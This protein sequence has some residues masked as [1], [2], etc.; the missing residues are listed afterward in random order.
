MR[1]TMRYQ[2]GIAMLLL[3]CSLLVTWP[4]AA[5]TNTPS[6]QS[7]VTITGNEVPLVQVFRA[8]K[9][10]T[11]LTL[12]YSNQLL[13]DGEKISLNF[14]QAKLNDV[15]SFIFKNKN[16]NYVLQRNRI[17]LDKKELLPASPSATTQPQETTQ[18]AWLVRGI[19]MDPDGNPLPGATIAITGTSQGTVTD[20]MGVFSIKAN[21][22]DVLKIGMI[23][24]N[25][26][27]VKISS[28]KTLKVTLTAKVDKLNEVVVVGFG[29]QKKVTVTGA[30]SSVNMADM[31]S[32]VPSLTNALVGRVAGVISMQ[33]N[34]G[35]P[36]YDAPTFTIRGIGTFMGNKSPLIIVDGVQREDVNSTYGGAFNNIDPE[37]IQSISLLKDASA[38]AVYGAKGANG[39]LIITTKKGIAGKPK[40]S[41]KA[42][43]GL[44]GFAVLPKMLDGVNYMKLY[45]EARVND[46]NSPVYTEE[47]IRKTESGLDP[48]LYPNVDWVNT[49]YKKWA[50]MANTNVNVSGGGEAMRYYV[51]MSFYNQDGQYNVTK[52]NGYNPNL[53]FKR[54]DFRSNVDLNLTKTTLL[55]L[56]LSSM[57]VNTRY[58][59]FPAKGI[60]YSTYAANPIMLP[61]KYPDRNSGPTNNGGNNPFNMVQN[62]GY[63]TEFR[64]TIQSVLSL[65]QKLDA[66]TEG[67]SATARFSFDTYSEFDNSRK[68]PN[69]LYNASGRNPDGSL[70]YSL[71]RQGVNY[72]PYSS[73]SSGERM[74]YL[75][76]NLNYDR[77]FGKHNIGGL[78]V[79][80]IRNRLIGSA[81]NLKLSIPF[82]N[83][84]AAAR[85]TY[86][87]MD[88]YLAEVNMGA[89]G[90]ENFAPGKR[91]G[92]FPAASVG[93]V[94]SKEPFFDAVSKTIS[95]LKVRAS[96]GM[97]GND[98]IGN[99]D[100]FGY[101]TY[102]DG[103]SGQ[104]FG[105]TG[106]PVFTGGIATKVIGTENLTWEKSAKTN[107]GL[108][109][110]LFN[111]FNLV[112][113]AFRDQRSS[114][115][116]LRNSISPIGGYS[117]LTIYGNIGEMDNRGMDGSIEYTE[118]LG[119]D[120]SLRVF[121]NVTYAKNKIVNADR[122]KSLYSYYPTSGYMYGELEG[123]KSLGLFVNKDDVQNNPKQFRDV[124]YPGDIKYADL[125]GDGR[126]DGS[127]KTYL[128]KS[129]FPKWS[130]GFGF[131]LGYKR[132]ELS[133]VFAGVADVA[134]MA[135][136]QDISFEDYGTP[137]VGVVPFTG[138]GQYP[139][140]IISDVLN[141]WTPENPSQNVHYPRITI[142]NGSDN[143]YVNSDWWLRD[144]SF[145]RLRQATLSYSIITAAM[146][147]KGIS[148]LQVYTGATNMLTFSRFK[149]WDP[150]L[151]NNAAKYPFT[152]TVTLGLRAQF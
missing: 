1:K 22:E 59:G 73:S 61:V 128:G 4:S 70:I 27:E 34:G 6:L 151:G 84:S 86:S 20:V 141:R 11:G 113:D 147:R 107:F 129:T 137:G 7:I 78:V 93:Y 18:E 96:Y 100:R 54:Y 71:V 133:A 40:V 125:N 83:Q 68:G 60:W 119:K 19:V 126:V 44:S 23:G 21:K 144:G 140:A 49:V 81:G 94:I 91:W 5:Q 80:S 108:E 10:Q 101:L 104:S 88:K 13:N 142:T 122:P 15:L 38:T 62:S 33:T 43:T 139:A 12:V 110:G 123:Y 115:L 36:G 127:D 102:Y 75:E 63:S 74:M 39:V 130:Y 17:V 121:G 117:D 29:N 143:N 55:S 66:I 67:L 131:N 99:N 30:V 3:L 116:V 35:E 53:N 85:V 76:G 138:M 148:S 9:K 64:P 106:S 51:S 120:V 45:N 145:L 25:A 152:K 124:L 92:Y 87:F 109:V 2:P 28:Q 24:M 57:L 105:S 149:L 146:K 135:N 32:P 50:S 37:D 132:F 26:E 69:D 14:Q 82:R 134:I 98:Q 112:V 46:N 89:T 52:I 111:K 42:E 90:S 47:T 8:I 118:Q 31:K 77:S 41:A 48:Y 97:T 79:G 58:P 150:E 16:I 95:L 136:G 114:I 56:N 103:A 72:L 65:N